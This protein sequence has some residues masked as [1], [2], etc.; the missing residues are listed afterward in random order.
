MLQKF[1]SCIKT[2]IPQ[3]LLSLVTLSMSWCDN[4]NSCNEAIIAM[5]CNTLNT[6]ECQNVFNSFVKRFTSV[7]STEGVR[8]CGF[9]TTKLNIL[10]DSTMLFHQKFRLYF[11]SS[12][13]SYSL[14]T[15][16]IND[17][18]PGFRV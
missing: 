18:I 4:E 11:F 3:P 12:N 10:I 14:P 8:V 7:A 16:F 6:N 13:F 1:S 2:D 9:E 17:K 15:I 5:I